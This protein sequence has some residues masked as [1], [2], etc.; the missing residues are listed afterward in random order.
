MIGYWHDTV[1]CLSVCL[2]VR[3]AVHCG[4]QGRCSGFKVVTSCTYH[5]T[6]YS[7]LQTFFL[8]DVGSYLLTTKHSTVWFTRWCHLA[9]EF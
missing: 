1:V 8:Y 2:S 9:N 4:A 7:L 5:G 6:S 3:N